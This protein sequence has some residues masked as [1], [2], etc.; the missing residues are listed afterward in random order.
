VVGEGVM[1][2]LMVEVDHLCLRKEI[3]T[4]SYPI[5]HGIVPAREVRRDMPGHMTTS[6]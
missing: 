3:K 1:M 5:H 6:L 2:L 4:K